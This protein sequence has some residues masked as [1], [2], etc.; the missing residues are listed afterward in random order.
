MRWS[1]KKSF[2]RFDDSRTVVTPMESIRGSH[3]RYCSKPNSSVVV[4]GQ[5]FSGGRIHKM[6]LPAG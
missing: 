5:H 4:G 1:Q 2:D 6:G 3:E